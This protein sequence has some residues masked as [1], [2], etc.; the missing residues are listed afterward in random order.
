MNT[1]IQQRAA[2]I[3]RHSSLHKAVLQGTIAQYQDIT[4]S[5]ALVLGLLQQG[6]TRYF[7]IFGH[8]STA[9]AEVLRIYEYHGLVHTYNL[10]HET[11][12]SHAATMLNMLTGEVAAVVT[13]IGPGALHAFAGSLASASN[14]AGVYHI[15]GDETTHD[16]GFNMQQIPKDEQA[17][18][19]KL[20]SVMGNAYALYEP[21][22]VISALKRGAVCTKGL[23]FAQPFFLLAPMNVQ[24]AVLTHFNLLQLPH[25]HRHVPVVC[26]DDA[27]FE[28][29][30]ALAKNAKRVTIKIGNGARGCGS[31]IETLANL[32]DAAIVSGPSS[33]GIVPYTN[34]RYMGVGG[35]KGSL[36]GNFAMEADCIIVIGARGVCQWD[37][38]GT[39]WK[40]ARSIVNFN[41]NPFHAAH[42]N[43]CVSVVGD[44]QGNLQRWIEHLRANGFSMGDS[45]SEWFLALQEKKAQWQALK[46]QRFDCPVLFDEMWKRDVLTQPA[47]IKTACDFA[48]EHNYIKV[49][50]AGD[51]QAN[52]FQIIEDKHEKQTI[53]ETGASYMGFAS[54]S[55]LVSGI[56]DK[57]MMA[58]CGD[59]SFIMNPQILI[60]GVEHGANATIIIFDN[61]RMAAITGLQYAQYGSEYKTSDSVAVDYVAMAHSVHGVQGIYGGYTPSELMQALQKADQYRGLSL[62]HVP[63]YYGQNELGGMG[64]FGSWNVGSWCSQVQEEY[65]RQGW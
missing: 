53:T 50:D 1:G 19:L 10:R 42:Y 3:A 34:P 44:A 45:H 59:G 16:E 63:V 32:L 9:I 57:K 62:I 18:F 60:D 58:F 43:R 5:E 6:V 65:H 20:C 2:A 64:V 11:A 27:V 36:S 15:Y 28:K 26:Y 30:T 7:G 17:L 54:S 22:S 4:V 55:V 41:V 52:G 33:A 37:C 31:Y 29:A 48:D 46:Q 12:A 38:S 24:P 35:S 23:P 8:G 51:V 47:A 61:R 25:A 49:F 56:V 13:S 14:G 40:N 21:W 39:A